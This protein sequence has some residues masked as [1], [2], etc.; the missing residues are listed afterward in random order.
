MYKIFKKKKIFF[1]KKKFILK[2]KKKKKKKKKDGVQS[3]NITLNA[4]GI[5]LSDNSEFYNSLLREFNRYSKE[6]ELNI[7]INLITLSDS[8]SSVSL[9]DSIALIGQLYAKKQIK[10]DIVFY[11]NLDLQ[12]F[13][14]YFVDLSRWI[15]PDILQM[16]DPNIVSDICKKNNK[17][18]GLVSFFFF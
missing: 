10:Y 13:D 2:L 18:V 4:L 1:K 9:V 15:D 16:Y 3:K 7:D 12:N 8:N 17:L 11:Y 6:Q 5:S 14:K